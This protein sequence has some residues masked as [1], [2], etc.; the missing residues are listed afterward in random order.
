VRSTR[1]GQLA[2]DVPRAKHAAALDVRAALVSHGA[3]GTVGSQARQ[4]VGLQSQ[5][6]TDKGAYLRLES[7]PAKR[8]SCCFVG[9]CAAL[10]L[11]LLAGR[12]TLVARWVGSSRAG[13]GMTVHVPFGHK[14]I[15]LSSSNVSSAGRGPPSRVGDVRRM[16][17]ALQAQPYQR[18]PA[19]QVWAVPTAQMQADWLGERVATV[20][21][22]RAINNVI[23]GEEDA[24]WGPNAI[25][26]CAS[27]PACD[28][29]LLQ[30]A[31]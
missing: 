5:G 1:F 28:L 7:L 18:S 10:N 29:H 30:A 3:A 26:R 8:P 16:Q 31:W 20:D 6:C 13:L 19:S 22:D 4:R 12:S 11:P 2:D 17:I 14:Q 24:G 23:H 25:F 9:C 15:V 27:S 21:V